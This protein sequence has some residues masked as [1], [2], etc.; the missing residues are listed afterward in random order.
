MVNRGSKETGRNQKLRD[1][2]KN[3]DSYF[4]EDAFLS[5]ELIDSTPQCTSESFRFPQPKKES[6]VPI[7]INPKSPTVNNSRFLPTSNM[8]FL[9][10]SFRDL[11]VECSKISASYPDVSPSCSSYSDSMLEMCFLG[12]E[13]PDFVDDLQ[14]E[15][16]CNRNQFFST[17]VDANTIYGGDAICILPK[18]SSTKVRISNSYAE[19]KMVKSGKEIIKSRLKSHLSPFKKLLNPIMK[20]K[21]PCNSSLIEPRTS[22]S[23]ASN[24]T[25][26]SK[27]K[28]FPKSLLNEISKTTQKIG[29]ERNPRGS[30]QVIKTAT[31]PTYL[32]AVLKWE[33]NRGDPSTE[34]SVKGPED[35]LSAKIWKTDN[36]Y[37]WVYTFHHCKLKRIMVRHGS[38]DRHLQPSLIIGQMLV[39]CHLCSDVGE[40][41]PLDNT[42]STEFN[43]YDIAQARRNTAIQRSRCLLNSNQTSVTECPLESNSSMETER[44]RHPFGLHSS[45][46]HSDLSTS[47]PWASDDLPPNLEIASIVTQSPAYVKVVT[48]SA[49][50]G[51][52]NREEVSASSLLDR[53]RFGGG[54]DCGGW[55]MGCPVV[56]FETGTEEPMVLFVKGK[57]ENIPALT[58]IENGKGKYSVHFLAQLSALQAFSICI[59]ILHSPEAFSAARRTITNSTPTPSS[60]CSRK[61]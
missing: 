43:L 3:A 23:I 48:P 54:C 7:H 39:S 28:F 21:S 22:S 25:T 58:I 17:G 57:K 41:G 14:V 40:S 61:G 37:N 9:D 20:S 49:R 59:A 36:P 15:T 1:G 44:P 51:L 55:D 56:V 19:K 38:K 31:F 24:T 12:K 5:Y 26:S 27:G 53:S 50:H 47:Y 42:A 34:F 11:L 4:N 45:E 2:G 30:G 18:S 35:V 6:L 32:H 46:F 52:P 13:G 10:L 8:E 16:K 60:L 33:F 29:T